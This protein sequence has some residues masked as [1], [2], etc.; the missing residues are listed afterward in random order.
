ML[1]LMEETSARIDTDA[2][3]TALGSCQTPTGWLRAVDLAQKV[4]L[5][6][7][8]DLVTFST[9]LSTGS[10]EV[11]CKLALGL[12][13]GVGAVSDGNWEHVLPS[14]HDMGRQQF[15]RDAFTYSAATTARSNVSAWHQTSRLLPSLG[16]D[17]LQVSKIIPSIAMSTDEKAGCWQSAVHRSSC[18]QAKIQHRQ[19]F[20][21]G[22]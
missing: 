2:A 20:L 6:L 10:N 18:Q 13:D 14:G 21:G 3:N 11:E 7:K 15:Q 19:Q 22:H 12:L 8:P 4:P 1:S 17:C 5:L 9:R 16:D